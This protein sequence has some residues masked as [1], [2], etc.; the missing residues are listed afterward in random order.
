MRQPGR[1]EEAAGLAKLRRLEVGEGEEDGY[2]I[3]G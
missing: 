2:G 1:R 3:M